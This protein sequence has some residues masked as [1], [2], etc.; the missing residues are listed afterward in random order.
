MKEEPSDFY[1][2]S[3][4]MFAFLQEFIKIKG[5]ANTTKVETVCDGGESALFKQLFKTWT[6]K[7]QTNGL[8]RTHAVGRVGMCI[9]FG[10]FI[11]LSFLSLN[12][13]MSRNQNKMRKQRMRWAV[14]EKVKQKINFLNI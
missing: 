10:M 13:A 4:Y 3:D 9:T 5:Y 2:Y 12:I 14:F 8:G 7:D 11:L 1:L 6:V